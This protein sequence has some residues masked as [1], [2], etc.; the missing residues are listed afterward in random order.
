M[1]LL[2]VVGG[3]SVGCLSTEQVCSRARQIGAFQ[4]PPSA[5]RA[6]NGKVEGRSHEELEH[7]KETSRAFVL[8]LRKMPGVHRRAMN[9][10]P[11]SPAAE[12]ESSSMVWLFHLLGSAAMLIEARSAGFSVTCAALSA[13]S[14]L[15]IVCLA[16]VVIIRGSAQPQLLEALAALRQAGKGKRPGRGGVSSWPASVLG[17]LSPSASNQLP[18]C[19]PAVC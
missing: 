10:L 5:G 9:S 2:G 14:V 7:L 17:L 3:Y 19:L 4:W 11:G 8:P 6:C 16:V 1:C 15:H 13:T 12:K 18:A